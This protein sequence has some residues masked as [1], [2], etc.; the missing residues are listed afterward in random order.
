MP[1]QQVFLKIPLEVSRPKS[2]PRD[3]AALMELVNSIPPTTTPKKF[4]L[5]QIA[6]KILQGM[7]DVGNEKG[8]C[9]GKPGENTFSQW[10]EAMR[11]FP[12]S[13]PKA[14]RR[15]AKR[16]PLFWAGVQALQGIELIRIRKCMV[17]ENFFWATRKDKKCCNK[18][19][20]GVWRTRRWRES[21]AAKYKLQR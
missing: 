1:V 18:K 4:P 15:L 17:C 14:E 3:L 2:A 5:L 21:Y 6:R 11:K 20:N 16:D 7:V 13:D 8:G 12:T 10:L 19:C 9:P